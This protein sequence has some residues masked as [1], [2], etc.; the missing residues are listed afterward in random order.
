MLTRKQI[1]RL[2]KSR[3]IPQPSEEEKEEE[4]DYKCWLVSLFD[5]IYSNRSENRQIDD[6]RKCVKFK[7]TIRV[8]L[9]PILNEYKQNNLDTKLWYSKDDYELFKKDYT[10][11]IRRQKYNSI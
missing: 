11:E 6:N 1:W 8:I 2:A 9:I 7:N 10:E 5:Y 3:N 4:E